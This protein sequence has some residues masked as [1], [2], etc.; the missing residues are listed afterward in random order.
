MGNTAM[1]PT[2]F[3]DRSGMDRLLETQ[4]FFFQPFDLL[5]WI[6]RLPVRPVAQKVLQLHLH[7]AATRKGRGEHYDSDLSVTL[8]ADLL[9]VSIDAINKSHQQ[10]I[11]ENLIARTT[12]YSSDGRQLPS[13]TRLRMPAD[14]YRQL[15]SAPS[16]SKPVAKVAPPSDPDTTTEAGQDTETTPSGSSPTQEVPADLNAVEKARQAID[17]ADTLIAEAKV[18]EEDAKKQVNELYKQNARDPIDDFMSKVDPL[19]IAVNQAVQEVD[20]VVRHKKRCIAELENLSKFEGLAKAA[21]AKKSDTP[22]TAPRLR[23]NE[24][25]T[26]YL[27]TRLA[28][29][30]GISNPTTIL[31]EIIFHLTDGVYGRMAFRKAAN[32]ATALVKTGRWRTPKGYTGVV[33]A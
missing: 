24:H 9:G 16:R 30:R 31:R 25:Q 8:M 29:I 21:G 17:H 3:I 15:F 33:T 10:L 13:L 22:L 14:D 20:V 1:Q 7:N 27:S 2:V 26:R 12:R 19:S 28:T 18:R 32:I 11:D 6:W 4:Y 23:L 5:T